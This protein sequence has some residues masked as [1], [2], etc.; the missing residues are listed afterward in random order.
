MSIKSCNISSRGEGGQEI[1]NNT[2]HRQWTSLTMIFLKE[3]VTLMNLGRGG[4]S[5]GAGLVLQKAI[6]SS[7]R[8]RVRVIALSRTV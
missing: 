7:P 4:L 1:L 8:R 3:N 5:G 2:P 6:S